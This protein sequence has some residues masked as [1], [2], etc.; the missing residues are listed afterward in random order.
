M[1]IPEK[2]PRYLLLLV[3]GLFSINVL[4]Q[5]QGVKLRAE[6]WDIP[7]HGELLIKVPELAKI[8]KQWLDN[9]QQTIE[10]RYPGGE[11]G[12]IWVEELT[13]WLISLGIPA[14]AIQVSPGSDAEDVINIVLTEEEIQ[15]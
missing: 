15:R 13:D 4:A 1:V 11:A 8:V 3:C 12:E 2:L 9:Q 5:E 6:T 14:R 10:L 7:R